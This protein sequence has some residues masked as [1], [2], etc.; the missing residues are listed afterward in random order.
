L[1]CHKK[2]IFSLLG[3]VLFI[4]VTILILGIS[5]TS[6]SFLRNFVTIRHADCRVRL[7]KL[8][9]VRERCVCLK[10]QG[11]TGIVVKGLMSAL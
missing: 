6:A 10:F 5:I 7:G 2:K 8:L 4:V 9:S 3:F 1:K 11:E